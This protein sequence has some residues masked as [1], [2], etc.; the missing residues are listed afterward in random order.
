MISPSLI[1]KNIKVFIAYLP[2]IPRL[3]VN[4]DAGVI[5]TGIWN[6]IASIVALL[7]I[8]VIVSISMMVT[9]I[10]TSLGV[11]LFLLFDVIKAVV[12]V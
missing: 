6:A 5:F 8:V 9:G 1:Q 12:S 7:S 4:E 11:S 3:R 2:N 10:K